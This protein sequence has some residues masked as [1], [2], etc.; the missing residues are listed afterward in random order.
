MIPVLWMVLK[1]MAAQW[2][3]ELCLFLGLLVASGVVTCVPLYTVGALQDSLQREMLSGPNYPGTYTVS[4]IFTPSFGGGR[5]VKKRGLLAMHRFLQ[6]GMVPSR[7]RVPIEA[8]GWSAALEDQLELPGADNDP[9][10]TNLAQI[11]TM[12]GLDPLIRMAEG[13][14]PGSAARGGVV[15]AA[16]TVAAADELGLVVGRIYEM[17]STLLDH[18]VNAFSDEDPPTVPLRLRLVGT[19]DLREDRLNSPGWIAAPDPL[20]TL[21]VHPRAFL[22]DLVRRRGLALSS[23]DATWVMDHT[24]VR[25]SDLPRL[26]RSFKALERELRL[27]DRALLPTC[28]PG[29]IFTRFEEKKRALGLM[30]LV[31]ALPALALIVYY[32]VL[33]AGV[34]VDQRRG[35]IAMIESRGAGGLQ[36]TASFALEWVVLGLLCLALGPPF[37]LFLAQVVGASAGFLNFVDRRALPIA[38][39]GEAYL[40][41]GVLALLMVAAATIPAARAANLSIVSYRNTRGRGRGKPFWQRYC[42][43]LILLGACAYGYRTLILQARAAGSSEAGLD[44]LLDPFLFILPTLLAAAGGLL[45]LRILPFLAHLAEG[46][47]ARGRG[48]SLHMSL[49]EIARNTWRYRPLILLVVLTTATG[50]YGAAMARTLDRNTQDRVRYAVGADAVLRERWFRIKMSGSSAGR[51]GAGPSGPPAMDEDTS[52]PFEPPFLVHKSLP[53]VVSAARVQ[54]TSGVPVIS[55]SERSGFLTLMAVDPPDFAR[56]AWFRRDFTKGHP[57]TY[58][59]ALTRHPGGIL[60]S[61]NFLARGTHRP[62]DTLTLEINRQRIEFVILG[63]VAFWPTLHPGEGGFAVANLGHVIDRSTLAPYDVWLRLAPGARLSPALAALGKKGIQVLTVMDARRELYLARRDP[64]KMGL[65]GIISIGFCVAV[66]LTVIGYLLHTFISMRGRLLQFGV[67]RAVG[68]SLGQLVGLLVMEQLWSVG[69]GLLFGTILG[70][71]IS[72]VF[73]PF[74]RSA[75]AF[76]GETPPFLVVIAK[77]DLGLIYGVLLPVLLLALCILGYSL[78]RLQVHQAVKLGEDG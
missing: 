55:G 22:D 75:A 12:T 61:K 42:L 16:C 69:I 73:V 26:L 76:A 63:A 50:I 1:R 39:T 56:T 21:F 38:M 65:Y 70:R 37:G 72:L 31:L 23:W 5:R 68:L 66:L 49:L 58:L 33:A 40:Y 20:S 19:F 30:M 25:V 8:S 74:L 62:G 10:A 78:A 71:A 2:R 28:T 15:E 64:Q 18:P 29:D 57:Y 3:L 45:L 24:R 32:T 4:V 27:F 36:L 54:V 43:D 67:L 77:S 47:S 7:L 59:N 14:P 9:S 6:G 41:A 48:A 13:R 46:A 52:R 11:F 60:V 34:I 53:G 51:P 44:K 17:R 35:E